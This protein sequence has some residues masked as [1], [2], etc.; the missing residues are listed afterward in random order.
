MASF[1][2]LNCLAPDDAAYGIEEQA[3]A[4]SLRQNAET[5]LPG[6]SINTPNGNPF[7]GSAS[8]VAIVGISIAA[9]FVG[10]W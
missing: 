7:H 9:V 3:N 10:L 4:L 1:H 2:Q 8:P 5:F 6:T